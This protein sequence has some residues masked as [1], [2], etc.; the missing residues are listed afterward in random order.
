MCR[1]CMY[2]YAFYYFI[3][4]TRLCIFIFHGIT[5]CTILSILT[6]FNCMKDEYV[7]N[8]IC[9]CQLVCYKYKIV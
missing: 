8:V 4:S 7:Y 1:K 3:S 5:K 2:V 9:K 6:N